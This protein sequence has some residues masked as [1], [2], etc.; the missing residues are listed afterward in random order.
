M[1]SL[2]DVRADRYGYA[3]RYYDSNNTGYYS[4][5]SSTSRMDI[6]DANR[7]DSR[8]EVKGSL[9]RDINNT[10]R[11][12]NPSSRSVVDSITATGDMRASIFYDQ[13][14]TYYYTNPSA[15]SR[16]NSVDVRNRLTVRNHIYL[17]RSVSQGGSCSPSGLVARF[18]NGAIAS[19]T[20]GRWKAADGGGSVCT[21]NST[22]KTYS[23]SGSCNVGNGKTQTTSY[24]FC[25]HDQTQWVFVSSSSKIVCSR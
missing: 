4:D 3:Q 2:G 15:T 12:V 6:V 5:P 14:N 8:G 9:F 13:D 18:S 23:Y 16:I 19:C 20:S 21:R 22:K 11:Y 24:W 10:G 25:P 7:L 17:T 1:R